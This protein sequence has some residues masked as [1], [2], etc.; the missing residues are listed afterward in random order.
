[1]RSL[2][3]VLTNDYGLNLTGW[4]L[5]YANGIS[6]NGATIVGSG[7]DPSGQAEAWI[8][9]IPEAATWMMV[10]LGTG[11]LVGLWQRLRVTQTAVSFVRVFHGE[12]PRI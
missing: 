8:A 6:S 12:F 2:Q 1:M 7:I 10:I 11:A 9:Q 5:Q 3:A 4:T